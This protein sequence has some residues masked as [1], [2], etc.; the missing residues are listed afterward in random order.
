MVMAMY[1]KMTP[2]EFNTSIYTA[3]RD[4]ANF[5]FKVVKG[6]YATRNFYNEEDV[7]EQVSDGDHLFALTNVKI[8]EI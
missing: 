6:P 8:A 4:F 7:Y 5:V 3:L 1:S 2:T